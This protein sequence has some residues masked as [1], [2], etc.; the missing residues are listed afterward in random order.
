VS[1]EKEAEK[2]KQGVR[3]AGLNFP[4]KFSPPTSKKGF[5]FFFFFFV[6]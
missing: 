3:F 6:Q 5:I 1:A 4:P 2:K